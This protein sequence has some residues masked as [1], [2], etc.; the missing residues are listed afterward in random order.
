M[1]EVKLTL[2]RCLF[3]SLRT[4]YSFLSALGVT[5]K[6]DN[7]MLRSKEPDATANLTVESTGVLNV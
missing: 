1:S 4:R 7:S 3:F 6:V 2:N 5:P